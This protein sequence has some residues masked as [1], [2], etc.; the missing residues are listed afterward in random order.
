MKSHSPRKGELAFE[1][2]TQLTII[3]VV[4]TVVVGLILT[5]RGEIL[6]K[7]RDISNPGGNEPPVNTNAVFVEDPTGFSASEFATHIEACWVDTR[8]AE[9]SRVCFVLKGS[10]TDPKLTAVTDITALLDS[11]IRPHVIF[12]AADFT[13]DLFSINYEA[14]ADKIHIKS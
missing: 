9:E 7:W 1:Y 10:Y 5:F 6:E 2:M 3:F 11:N 4:L 8:D 13:K 14:I 12:T